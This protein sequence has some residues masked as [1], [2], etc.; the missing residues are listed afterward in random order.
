MVSQ[1]G[2]PVLPFKSVCFQEQ[3]FNDYIIFKLTKLKPHNCDVGDLP[4]DIVVY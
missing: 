1:I 3:N 4:E 2:V